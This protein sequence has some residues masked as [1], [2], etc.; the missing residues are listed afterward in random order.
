MRITL[1]TPAHHLLKSR[2]LSADEKQFVRKLV[3]VPSSTLQ[4]VLTA[5]KLLAVTGATSLDND[6]V[7]CV[8]IM[9]LIKRLTSHED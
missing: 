8:I 1:A 9:I 5:C 3:D 4:D 7:N 6:D 2:L